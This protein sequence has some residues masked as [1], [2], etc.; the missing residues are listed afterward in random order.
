MVKNDHYTICEMINAKIGIFFDK[1][2]FSSDIL[3]CFVVLRVSVLV[4]C[5]KNKAKI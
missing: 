4:H 2:Y 5:T 3:I 1:R